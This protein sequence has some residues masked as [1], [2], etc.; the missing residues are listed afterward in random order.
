MRPLPAYYNERPTRTTTTTATTTTVVPTTPQRTKRFDTSTTTLNEYEQNQPWP[1]PPQPTVQ[2]R[3]DFIRPMTP[4]KPC[5]QPDVGV[6]HVSVDDLRGRTPSPPVTYRSSTTIY[7]RDK[8]NQF[9]NG[10]IRT[11]S[12][13]QQDR[14]D[15]QVVPPKVV[16]T[17]DEYR[18]S[19]RAHESLYEQEQ[20]V[21]PVDEIESQ[22][23]EEEERFEITFEYQQQHQPYSYETQ[24][25]YDELHSIDR[26]SSKNKK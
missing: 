24:K 23:G 1:G 17:Y 6:I 21:C 22:E 13:P 12:A 26:Y 18:Y 7:T 16:E 19:P 25:H 8:N 10:E 2:R 9:D 5:V 3:D 11:W 15:H 4:Q 20:R 14:Y